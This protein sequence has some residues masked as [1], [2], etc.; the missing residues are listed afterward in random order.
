MK[1]NQFPP[2]WDEERGQKVIDYYENQTEDEAVAEDEAAFRH[3][4]ITNVEV[5]S[6]LVP[7]VHK[8]ITKHAVNDQEQQIGTKIKSPRFSVAPS[9]FSDSKERVSWSGKP[10]NTCA[11]YGLIN[12]MKQNLEMQSYIRD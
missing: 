8:L 7:A 6:Q 5:P 10:E 11:F 4:F 2:G 3:E 1:Q 12:L 9:T